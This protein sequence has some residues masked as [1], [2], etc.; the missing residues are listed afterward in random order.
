MLLTVRRLG[1][2]NCAGLCDA[3]CV[4]VG[5]AYST[6]IAG[7]RCSRPGKELATSPHPDCGRTIYPTVRCY[8]YTRYFYYVVFTIGD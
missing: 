2:A 1:V 5:I 7:L 8:I 3:Y 4:A 6:P